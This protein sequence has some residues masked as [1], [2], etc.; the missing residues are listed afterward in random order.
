M[1][2]QEDSCW[3]CGSSWTASPERALRLIDGGAARPAAV[4]QVST[5]ERLA[6]L[7]AEVRA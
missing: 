2:G 1:E 7:V 4:A 6:R 5:A 3:R